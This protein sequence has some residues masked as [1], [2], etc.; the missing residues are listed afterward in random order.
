MRSL[1]FAD[2]LQAA[3]VKRRVKRKP[4]GVQLFYYRDV[5]LLL[6]DQKIDI[7][8][9]SRRRDG[10]V[11]QRLK[12]RSA[13]EGEH[14]RRTFTRPISALNASRHSDPGGGPHDGTKNE[15]AP[16]CLFEI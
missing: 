5:Q 10:G 3:I 2:R 6:S 14:F 16:R 9:P 13:R 11:E 7:S 12:K 1:F 15:P 8:K 4:S